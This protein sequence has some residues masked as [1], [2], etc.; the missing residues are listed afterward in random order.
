M[1]TVTGKSGTYN[2]KT[3]SSAISGYVQWTETYDD[4]TYITTNQTTITQTVYLHRT[5]TY[6]GNYNIS[7]KTSRM[8]FYL[9]A[10]FAL[11]LVWGRGMRCA[12]CW[13]KEGLQYWSVPEI[14][15]TENGRY[16]PDMTERKC[17][18]GYKENSLRSTCPCN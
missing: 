10:T 13:I 2:I 6:S 18:Y 9:V 3:K 8:H 1:A 15:T 12:T 11:S 5:N 17:D 7:A 14:I 4:A 16:L